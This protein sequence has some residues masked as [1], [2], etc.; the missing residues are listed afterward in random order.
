MPDMTGSLI[1]IMEWPIMTVYSSFSRR[2]RIDFSVIVTFMQP[3][4][5]TKMIA[6]KSVDKI[7]IT[8]FFIGL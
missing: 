5:E 2:E 4:I 7:A 3:T 1:G 6:T 8:D